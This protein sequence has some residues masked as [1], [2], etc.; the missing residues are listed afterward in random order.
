MITNLSVP[1]K[2]L[3]NWMLFIQLLHA[4]PWLGLIKLSVK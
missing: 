2:F 3:N 1:L 4:G